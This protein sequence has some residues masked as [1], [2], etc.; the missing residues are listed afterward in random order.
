MKKCF[1]PLAVLLLAFVLTGCVNN[2]ISSLVKVSSTDTGTPELA[3]SDL[4][5]VETTLMANRLEVAQSL[6][7]PNASILTDEVS[8]ESYIM[9]QGRRFHGIPGENLSE[10]ASGVSKEPHEGFSRGSKGCPFEMEGD[11]ASPTRIFIASAAFKVEKNGETGYIITKPNGSEIKIER[12]LDNTASGVV[13]VD[14]VTWDVV[15]SDG[16]DDEVATL[17]NSKT[18]RTLKIFEDDDGNLTVIVEGKHHFHGTW[19]QDGTLELNDENA[20][21]QY[22]YSIAE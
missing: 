22:S 8:S 5:A 3:V 4:A 18:G 21:H 14:G 2:G 9:H 17:T 7:T 1:F 12:P 16:E 13:E 15:F 11:N 20:V 6:S 19:N 10:V